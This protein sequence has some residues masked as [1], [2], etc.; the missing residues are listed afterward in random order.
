MSRWS[1]NA[2][3]L[4]LGLTLTLSSKFGDAFFFFFFFNSYL[5]SVGRV[6]GGSN[7]VSLKVLWQWCFFSVCFFVPLNSYLHI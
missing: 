4:G 7:F 2:S 1:R 5:S 3:G 6:N